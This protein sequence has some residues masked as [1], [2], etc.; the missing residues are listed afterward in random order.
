MDKPTTGLTFKN[1]KDFIQWLKENHQNEEGHFIFLYKKGYETKGLT[2]Q[3]AL[4]AALCYGWI[5]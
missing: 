2:Y 4:T 3:D 1:Q 5:D